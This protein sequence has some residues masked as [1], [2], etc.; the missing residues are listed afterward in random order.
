MQDY[1][2]HIV[3]LLKQDKKFFSDN[4]EFLRNAAIQAAKQLDETLIKILLADDYAAKNFFKDIADVKLFDSQKFSYAVNN[5][6]F[7]PGSYTRFKNKIGLADENQNF[8]SE[9][10]NVEI[11][12]PYKDCVLEGGQTKDEQ[13]RPEIFFNE[14]LARDDIDVLLEPKV[15]TC[16]KKF[17]AFGAE[18]AATFS[19]KDNLIIKGNNLLAVASLLPR[20]KNKVKCIY[21]D[22]PYNTGNDSFGYN[23][24]FNHSSWL[25][26]MKTRL[27]FAKQLLKND[28]SIWISIDDDEQAYLKILC[29]EIF[30]R[31]NFVCN[32]IWEKKYT[33]SNDTKYLSEN[34]DYI[35]VYAKDKNNWQPN[36]LPRTEEM[37]KAYKNP[38]N[39]PR[40]V[41]KPTP[42]HA[43]S[44]TAAS[45]K[46]T[47][48]FKNGV[49]FT[50]PPGRYSRYSEE[51]LR[52]LDESNE[53]WFGKD[54]KSTPQKKTFLSELLKSGVPSKTL[55]RFDEVGHTHEAREETKALII[56][57][58]F[59]TPKPERL[60]Q[61]ILTLATNEGDI[62]LDN[63]LGS[64]TTA[65]VAH[66]MGRQY[67]GVEQMD[68]IE[69]VTVERLKKVIDGE[70][71]GISKAVNWKG[72]GSF[73]YCEL[74]K[75]NQ[76]F[77][78][79]IQAARDF[80]T[81]WEIKNEMVARGFISYKVIPKK[82]D[83]SKAEFAALTLEE[84]K[85]LLMEVLDK[86]FLYV[87]YCDIDDEDFA[88]SADDK[89]FSRSFYG[90]A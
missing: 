10:S 59:T 2:Q 53:I 50:P 54:G 41:W 85:R 70:Q 79:E 47:Y 66:K 20:F 63:F 82:F 46:F 68:Y 48:T 38:D 77:V 56:D 27:Q 4:G 75:L 25:T 24:R 18:S 43:R 72:G 62:V 87:N 37:D 49:T 74:A 39:D 65:A 11:I 35:L 58:S 14:T 60:I 31:Q 16:A 19:S 44:G 32:V 26:F 1:F 29:D 40:G 23:D 78:E 90:R 55:W 34:H 8:I 21:I 88:I 33:V 86:N 61:R 89:K 17:S 3:N 67:I 84:Q 57:N 81:I 51:T 30:G 22:V 71:G 64:G 80:E 7:L 13:K 52:K 28:G 83:E 76:N 15:L 9:S 42:L 36:P 45:A 73:I 12:F 69:T 6:E 5:Y